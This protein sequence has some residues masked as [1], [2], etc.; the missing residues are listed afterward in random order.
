[1][2]VKE[3]QLDFSDWEQRIVAARRTAEWKMGPQQL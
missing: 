1:M 3:Q 2:G